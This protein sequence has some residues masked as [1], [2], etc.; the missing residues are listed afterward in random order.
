MYVTCICHYHLP[1]HRFKRQRKSEH[2]G[3]KKCALERG[4]T[5][6]SYDTLDGGGS[7]GRTEDIE[8]DTFSAE[9]EQPQGIATEE[10]QEYYFQDPTTISIYI[11][12]T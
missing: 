2:S 4:N 8:I 3:H 6:A 12:S 5:P 10:T 7:R 11:H 9:A 1:L